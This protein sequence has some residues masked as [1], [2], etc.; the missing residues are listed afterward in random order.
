MVSAIRIPDTLIWSPAKALTSCGSTFHR[1]RTVYCRLPTT[2]ILREE[3]PGLQSSAG[4]VK[5][6]MKNRIIEALAFAHEQG[7]DSDEITQ[8]QWPYDC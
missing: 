2:V 3:I 5:E 7:K 6:R 4:H 8:W 1:M